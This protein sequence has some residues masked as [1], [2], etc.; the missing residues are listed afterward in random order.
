M[1]E[2]NRIMRTI[3]P[4]SVE[5]GASGAFVIDM[6]RN[7]VGWL[8]LKLPDGLEAGKNIWLEYADQQPAGKRFMTHNQRDQYVTSAASGQVIRSRFNYHGFRWV[9]LAGLERRP[10]PTASRAISSEPPTSP[11]VSSNLLTTF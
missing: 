5:D 2:P 1:V 3:T 8:E 11:R 7:F 9:Q 10:D 6:G 4:A